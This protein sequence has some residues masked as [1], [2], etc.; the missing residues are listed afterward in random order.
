[1]VLHIDRLILVKKYLKDTGISSLRIVSLLSEHLGS[2]ESS[3]A[4]LI[5]PL[6]CIRAICSSNPRLTSLPSGFAAASQQRY[7]P[8]LN[9][10]IP[11]TQNNTLFEQCPNAGMGTK[12]KNI[13]LS[14]YAPTI[15]KRLE[16]AAPGVEL[17]NEDIFNL[18]A[19]CPFETMAKQRPS[20]FCGLF[21]YDEFKQFEY[22][23]DIEKFY[24]TG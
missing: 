5:G 4:R 12:E 13:W 17:D 6:V 24:K 3:R 21:T 23:G 10:V 1:M 7:N 18:L 8:Y 15:L 19:M 9:V 16:E 2:R 14:V 20:D 22:H 11:E